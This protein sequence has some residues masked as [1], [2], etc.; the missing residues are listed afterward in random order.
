MKKN[1][2]YLLLVFATGCWGLSFI[3]SREIFAGDPAPSVTALV[4]LRLLLASI[5][6][7]PVLLLM[8]QW[9]HL[10][11]GDWKWFLLISLFEPFLYHLC[12]TGA[13][14]MVNASLVSVIVATVPLFVP[15][16]V[17]AVYK[18]KVNRQL[19]F[20]V[21]ISIVGVVAMT[22]GD[23]SAGESKLKGILILL[24]AVL[25]ST[26]YMLILVKI[27]DNYK[28]VTITTYQNLFGLVYFIPC[29]LL[30]DSTAISNLPLYS[31]K[32]WMLI[33]VLGLLCSML[34]YTAYNYGFKQIGASQAAA[35]MN[36]SPVFTLAA[37]LIIGQEQFAWM[38]IVGMAIVIVGLFVAQMDHSQIRGI[39]PRTARRIRQAFNIG[40][41]PQQTDNRQ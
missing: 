36:I 5:I 41:K 40:G 6:T 26:A 25:A 3:F 31:T 35:F 34:A 2:A 11:R 18:Q 30:T 12:E 14:S 16:G 10:R 9:E 21:L 38:K 24:G 29:T 37:A 17:A 1:L 32:T 22:L 33:L 20:G 19:L 4:T 7:I 15:F 28:P 23:D 13:V 27:A 39:G 8:R